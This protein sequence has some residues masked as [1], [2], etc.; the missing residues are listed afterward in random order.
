MSLEVYADFVC[1]WCYLSEDRIRRLLGSAATMAP[2]VWRPFQLQ[3]TMPA[4]G[5][6]RTSFFAELFG[7]AANAAKAW[8][9]VRRRIGRGSTGGIGER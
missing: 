7:S 8:E 1:P 2:I 9:R 3:P 4:G 6:E 5:V